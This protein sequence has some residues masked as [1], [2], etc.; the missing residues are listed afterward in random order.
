MVLPLKKGVFIIS[1]DTE[2]AWGSVH[3]GSYTQREGLFRQVRPCI[4]RLIKLLE[5][6]QIHATWA[7]VGHLF[8]EQCQPVNGVKHPEIIRPKYDWFPGDWFEPDP[9]SRLEEAPFWYGRDIIEQI[10]NCAISQEIGCHTFSHV[11]V[12]APGC[13]RE[14]FTSELT[15]CRSEAEKLGLTLQSFVFPRNSIGHLDVLFESG[16]LTYRGVPSVWYERLPGL[17]SR[18]ARRLNYYLPF[19]PPVA[20][21]GKE[22][23]LINLPA[24]FFYPVTYKWW[25]K[26]FGQSRVSKAK[27]GLSQAANKRRVFHLWFHPFNL[28]ADPD[29]LLGDLETIFT[30]VCRYR[31]AGRLDNLTMGDL[32]LSL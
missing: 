25:A 7:V 20:L 32:A 3:G 16:F 29:G 28:A 24:S 6:F 4:S 27:R 11:R 22:N 31:D 17:L 8:L 30:E 2:L 19:P 5:K 26:I 21:P 13:S 23:G 12:G 15:A 9:C 10:N 18:I 1:I 14:C